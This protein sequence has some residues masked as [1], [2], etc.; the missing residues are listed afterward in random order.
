MTFKGSVCIFKEEMERSKIAAL[1]LL[2]RQTGTKHNV[3]KLTK[4][5]ACTETMQ[6]HK[7]VKV[8]KEDRGAKV[9]ECAAGHKNISSAVKCK[10]CAAG[11]AHTVNREMMQNTMDEN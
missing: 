5:V 4:T 10:V 6:I 9:K 7:Q 2:K 11:T 3:T 8:L 1:F